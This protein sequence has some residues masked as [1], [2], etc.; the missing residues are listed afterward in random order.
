MYG[1]E[2]NIYIKNKQGRAQI[3]WEKKNLKSI[4]KDLKCMHFKENEDEYAHAEC[5]STYKGCVFY[6]WKKLW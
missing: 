3:I 2:R 5:P 6:N 4:Y 1:N